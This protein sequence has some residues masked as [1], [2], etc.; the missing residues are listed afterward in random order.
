MPLK[1]LGAV[2]L[3]LSKGEQDKPKAAVASGGDSMNGMTLPEQLQ[4]MDVERLRA[5]VDNLAFY[6]GEQWLGVQRRRVL[7][8]S[9]R[10]VSDRP[11]PAYDMRLRLGAV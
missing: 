10:Y 8:M 5:Y 11:T 9:L 4:R 1:A 7:A 2:T 6:Q 3:S